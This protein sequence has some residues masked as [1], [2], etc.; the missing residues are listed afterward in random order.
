MVFYCE[1]GTVPYGVRFFIAKM[2]N[3]DKHHFRLPTNVAYP[4]LPR[5]DGVN[6]LFHWIHQT[7]AAV[8]SSILTCSISAIFTL[9][10]FRMISELRL[11]SYYLGQVDNSNER[12]NILRDCTNRCANIIKC[13]HTIQRIFG[14]VI[15]Q[16]FISNALQ[17]CAC[18]FLLSQ[19]FAAETQPISGEAKK[20]HAAMVD[21]LGI[22]SPE[23]TE[24]KLLNKLC[25]NATISFVL[26]NLGTSTF[27]LMYIAAFV[28]IKISESCLCAFAGSML[29]AESEDYRY[30]AYCID[31]NGNKRLMTWVLVEINQR[32]ITLIACH[33]TIISLNIIVSIA[34]T[35][36]SYYF[37]NNLES[38]KD[39]TCTDK[40]C[41]WS[42]PHKSRLEK[43]D[44]RLLLEHNCFK[45]KQE[46]DEAK[47][48]TRTLNS[49]NSDTYTSLVGEADET[50][51]TSGVE[52]EG[53][54]VQFQN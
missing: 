38:S 9:L 41:V 50:K 46:I 28:L 13:S 18:V 19:K 34:N 33:F 53:E 44:M 54:H 1:A 3:M 49:D 21:V 45:V 7:C 27:D 10:I 31:W 17:L 51:I 43:Y 20:D 48:K 5:H 40:K 25:S 15:L 4:W 36:I 24:T 22:N 52:M 2:S 37:L 29:I 8:N 39:I 26:W 14:P 42:A 11:M 35:T 47:I 32:P 23:M 6:F 30:A 16:M 12:E